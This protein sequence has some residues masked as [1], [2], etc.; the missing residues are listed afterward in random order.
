MLSE[1]PA[2]APTLWKPGGYLAELTQTT[3]IAVLAPSRGVGT[4]PVLFWGY[5][6]CPPARVSA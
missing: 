4:F 5:F 2:L 1:G 3:L 6:R